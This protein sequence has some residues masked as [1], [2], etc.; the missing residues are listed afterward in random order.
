MGLFIGCVNDDK[1]LSVIEDRL[2][3]E[4][5]DSNVQYFP[6]DSLSSHGEAYHVRDWAS[7]VL[8]NLREPVLYNYLGEG[9]FVR[10]T[11]LKTFYNPVVVRVSNF[12][13]TVYA[14]IKILKSKS[15]ENDTLEILKDTIRYLP[16]QKWQRIL[17]SLGENNYWSS[18]QQDTAMGAKDGIPWL[19]ECKLH[20]KYHYVKRWDEGNLS[21]K[22]LNLYAKELIDIANN[23]TSMRSDK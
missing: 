3:R 13:D 20:N 2:N 17:A 12:N 23:Y 15:S 21:S 5:P 7:E 18:K 9:E 6:I 19:L 8:F 14:S 11:W 16:L 10:L 4:I 22:E 1:K